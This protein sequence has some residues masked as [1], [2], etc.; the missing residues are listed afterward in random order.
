[1]RSL[2]RAGIQLVTGLLFIDRLNKHCSSRFQEAFLYG[3]LVAASGSDRDASDGPGH[4]RFLAR[5]H[6]RQHSEFCQR[7]P[8]HMPPLQ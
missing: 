1:M 4:D 2:R 7:L 8:F 3:L 5:S 6:P